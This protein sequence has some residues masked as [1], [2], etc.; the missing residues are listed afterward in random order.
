M[1]LRSSRTW[2]SP[3]ASWTCRSQKCQT[4]TRTL[5]ATSRSSTTL[6]SWASRAQYINNFVECRWLQ[7]WACRTSFNHRCKCLAYRAQATADVDLRFTR[8]SLCSASMTPTLWKANLGMSQNRAAAMRHLNLAK[9]AEARS[10]SRAVTI[11]KWCRIIWT[12]RNVF[13]SILITK[14]R[15]LLSPTSAN[16]SEDRKNPT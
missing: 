5:L 14:E 2:P 12:S 15:K 1:C 4:Q 9:N 6:L 11:L 3:T 8:N 13:S 10:S 16:H 7:P